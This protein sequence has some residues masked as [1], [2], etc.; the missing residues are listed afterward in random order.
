MTVNTGGLLDL[1][2]FSPIEGQLGGGGVVDDLDFH[3]FHADG[4]QRQRHRA[5]SP[6][7]FKTRSGSV[8][9]VKAGT[10]AVPDRYQHL[11]RHDHGQR[12]HAAVRHSPLPSTAAA[13]ELDRG[14]HHR[15]LPG[16]AGRQRGRQRG[17]T[18]SQA[19]TLFANLTGSNS[20]L[21]A[22]SAFGIDTSNA[23]APVVFSTLVQDSAAGSVG[24]TKLGAG[25][26]QVTNASNSYTGPTTVV[27]GQLML[28]GANTDSTAPGLVTVSNSTSGGLSILSLL[29]PNVLGSGGA[30]SVL[31]PISLNSTGGG[32]AILEI[33]A[34]LDPTAANSF[35]YV[36]SAVPAGQI[37]TAGQ[38]SL[39]AS[40]NTADV[41]GFSASSANY[42][43]RTVGLYTSSNLT[44][45]Q[46]LQC[47]TYIPGKLVL[48]SPTANGTL[49]LENPIDLY[50]A[51]AGTQ[52]VVFVD[53]RHG[54][55]TA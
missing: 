46:T 50:S 44:T 11:L 45:L 21:L 49:I 28:F 20:G 24:L 9:L 2:G 55:A 5:P 34:T 31:A 6:G 36:G 30:N 54:F 16:H 52:R 13:R 10:G 47:G 12:R 42:A 43:Q 7:R 41:V 38:I 26:L 53:S 3:G 22:G 33:G 19:G 27:N 18:V 39:G 40:G 4:Q 32:T 37:P 25:T 14:Q 35:S 8:S 15:R 23:T 1:H 29:N 51:S 48:G 17:F